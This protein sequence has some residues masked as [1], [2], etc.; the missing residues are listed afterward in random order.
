MLTIYITRHGET[1]WNLEGRMQGWKDS[2]LTEKGVRDAIRL[3]DHLNR[4]PFEAFYSSPSGRTRQTAELINGDRDIPIILDENLKEINMG[5]WEGRTHDEIKGHYP[6]E[7][8]AFWN[9]PHLYV[10][11]SGESFQDVQTRIVKAFE[12]ILAN[13]PTGNI[14]MVT[15][16]V[17][18]KSLI[19]H[20]QNIGFDR[21]W[22]PPFIHG[23]S[24]TVVKVNDGQQQLV[25][26][27][28][29]AHIK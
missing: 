9:A 19:V 23:T 11:T 18:I 28:D 21:L 6:E 24:L 14:L 16:A 12:T 27:G 17:A 4:I 7:Y 22:D 10:P 3:G 13:H 2:S 15:H 1:E 25:V 29:S 20:L 8:H 26:I 5:D